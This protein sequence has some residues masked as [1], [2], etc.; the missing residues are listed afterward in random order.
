LPV[1]DPEEEA[2]HGEED[3]DLPGLAQPR[4]DRRLAERAGERGWDRPRED[5]PGQPLIVVPDRAVAHGAEPRADIP[6]HVGPEVEDHRDER[7]EVKG[8]VEGLVEALVRFQV[9]PVPDPRHEDQVT[10][11]RDRQELRQALCYSERERL[12]VGKAPSLLPDA[13]HGEDD[14]D[15]KE[16]GGQSV[17]Q[18]PSAR[19]CLPSAH[20]AGA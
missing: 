7:P 2:E 11:R 19:C 8:D 16:D 18:P 12:P 4:L 20:R 1:G 10:G 6:H 3:R 9:V 14:R 17:D 13:R 5:V 15:G